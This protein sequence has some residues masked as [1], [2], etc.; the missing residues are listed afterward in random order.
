MFFK[1]MIETDTKIKTFKVV[2]PLVKTFSVS[3]FF[4][5]SVIAI[6]EMI[7]LN[8]VFYDREGYEFIIAVFIHCVFIRLL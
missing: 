3:V 8:I 5:T 6:V 4:L 2:T 1:I 7:K